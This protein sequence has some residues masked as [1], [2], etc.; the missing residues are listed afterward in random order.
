M[1]IAAACAVGFLYQAVGVVLYFQ[2]YPA[3]V[4]S[5]F[6]QDEAEFPA[7]TVCFEAWFN[8]T[9]ICDH[10]PNNCSRKDV[11][12]LYAQPKFLDSITLRHFGYPDTKKLFTCRMF[13]HVESCEPFDCLDW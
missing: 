13:S 12:L 7:V 10:F 4:S 9:K 2:S 8:T 1:A 6:A 3:V 11:M 5:I